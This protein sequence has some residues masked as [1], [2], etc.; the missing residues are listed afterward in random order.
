MKVHHQHQQKQNKDKK[1]CKPQLLKK[2]FK[3]DY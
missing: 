3:E 1:L 2:H